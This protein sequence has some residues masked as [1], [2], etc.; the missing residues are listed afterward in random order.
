MGVL[1]KSDFDLNS[2]MMRLGRSRFAPTEPTRVSTAYALRAWLPDLGSKGGALSGIDELDVWASQNARAPRGPIALD[3]SALSTPEL[4]A[5]APDDVD[6]KRSLVTRKRAGVQ[7]SLFALREH[8]VRQTVLAPTAAPP[9]TPHIGAG[10]V[11]APTAAAPIAMGGFGIETRDD[12]R[13]LVGT[14]RVFDFAGSAARVSISS[15]LTTMTEARCIGGHDWR[16]EVPLPPT[17]VGQVRFG[18]VLDVDGKTHRCSG[19]RS[20]GFVARFPAG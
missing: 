8:I 20:A 10:E 4:D 16:F 19:P 11:A 12:V 1:A 15:T 17:D 13:V 14:A 18:V 2:E 3:T 5:C 9:T 7:A 6:A